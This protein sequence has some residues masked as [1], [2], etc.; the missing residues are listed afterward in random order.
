MKQ[1]HWII[2]PVLLLLNLSISAQIKLTPLGGNQQLSASST[3][4][5][6][7]ADTLSLPFFDD[8]STY[9]IYPDPNKWVD[10]LV[11]VNRHF[12][13]RPPSLGVA[14]FD[15]LD[16]TGSPYNNE[17]NSSSYDVADILTSCPINLT[18]T[19]GQPYN[20]SDSIYLSYYVQANGYGYE[21]DQN[22]SLLLQ[23]RNKFG[24]WI[25]VWRKGGQRQRSEFEQY[26]IPVTDS[27]FIH[28]AFQFR[29]Y[30]FTR[31]SGNANHWNL[32]YVKMDTARQQTNSVHEDYAIQTLPSSLLDRYFSMPYRHFKLNAGREAADSIFFRASNLNDVTRNIEARVIASGNGIPIVATDFV[33]NAN[34]VPASGDALR[35]FKNF[36]LSGLSGDTVLIR[37]RYEVRQ[38]TIQNPFRG[39]DAVDAIQFFGPYFAYDDGS[40]ESGFGFDHDATPSNVSGQVAL[41]YNLNEEDTLKAIAVFFNQSIR[42]VSGRAITLKVWSNLSPVG[43]GVAQDEVIWERD[44][45]I[46][47]A[48]TGLFNQYVY[49]AVDTTLILPAG[50]FYIGWSQNSMFHA[51]IGFDNNHGRHT[52][53][54]QASPYIYYEVLGNWSQSNLPGGAL[55][56]RPFFGP[57]PSTPIVVSTP[58]LV[59]KTAPGFYPNPASD[60]ISL[61][62]SVRTKTVSILDLQG[63]TMKQVNEPNGEIALI[64]LPKGVYI[65]KF[66]TTDGQIHTTRLLKQ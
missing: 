60:H 48:D 2:I 10:Q 33:N 41:E 6:T 55:M 26:L 25:T 62:S 39:N 61:S 63:R 8:F 21:L 14:T 19:N 54:D 16:E 51:N 12:G 5:K 28:N 31:K 30:N 40:A 42:D 64:D 38:P 9:T 58:P 65:I 43:G 57:L 1:S 47:P 32:D 50:S 20:A 49:F 13:Y 35:R 15:H 17:L 23:F 7:E 44:I 66:E 45:L 27:V 11:Y 22:D 52:S 37:H 53:P 34:N 36:D 29:F 46:Q 56:M 3:V 24:D 4:F 18:R 59:Q